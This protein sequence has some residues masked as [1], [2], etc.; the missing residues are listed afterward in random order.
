MN[1]VCTYLEES[2]Q[3]ETPTAIH[4]F[5]RESSYIPRNTITSV[6]QVNLQG[7]EVLE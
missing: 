2:R 5:R 4:K 6:K 7:Y 3:N 1:T